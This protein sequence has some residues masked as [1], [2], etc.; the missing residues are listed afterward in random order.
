MFTV[1]TNTLREHGV[2]QF[3][4]IEL[5]ISDIVVTVDTETMIREQCRKYLKSQYK[6]FGK[7]FIDKQ[8]AWTVLETPATLGIKA[9]NTKET[10]D[11]EKAMGLRNNRIYVV[12]KDFEKALAA[13]KKSRSK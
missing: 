13:L 8:M 3:D 1:I 4:G 10:K 9:G 12:K 2:E 7:K 6:G 11:L 5:S